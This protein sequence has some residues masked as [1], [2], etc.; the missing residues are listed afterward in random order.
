MKSKARL[1]RSGYVWKHISVIVKK[2]RHE[3]WLWTRACVWLGGSWLGVW[4]TNFHFR[5]EPLGLQILIRRSGRRKWGFE[6][7]RVSANQRFLEDQG[8]FDHDKGQKSAISGAVS[9]GLFEVSPVDCFPFSPGLLCNLVRKWPQNVEK[10]APGRRTKRR[11]LSRLWLSWF[12]RS[13]WRAIFFFG[14]LHLRGA[15]L[16]LWK[17]VK[18]GSKCPLPGRESREPVKPVCYTPRCCSP[19]ANFPKDVASTN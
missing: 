2:C 1:Q 5:K 4:P 11:I 12:F 6:D 10:I 16:A 13:S 7:R 8:T 14:F 3:L 19:S 9:T 15:C 17:R 18:Q